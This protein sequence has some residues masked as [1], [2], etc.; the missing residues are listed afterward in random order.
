MAYIYTIS[1]PL[2]KAVVYVGA[3]ENFE[4]R[5]YAHLQ[6][7]R[8]K[9]KVG[10][11]IDGLYSQSISPLIEI[12]EEC[13]PDEML[14]METYWISQM[15]AWGFSLLNVHKKPGPN[16]VF[17]KPT[18]VKK[19]LDKYNFKNIKNGITVKVENRKR[20]HS[21][22]LLY[23]K[24]MNLNLFTHYVIIG[25]ELHCTFKRFKKPIK[26][27]PIKKAKEPKIKHEPKLVRFNFKDKIVGS[28]LT[29]PIEKHDSF[30]NSLREYTRR[31]NVN[32]VF[33]YIKKN[34]LVTATR[35]A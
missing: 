3:T 15:E 16:Q 33:T 6:S 21:S 1:H 34:N 2:T 32:M 25:G 20:F 29:V 19:I 10:V 30:K 4:T 14:I 8:K 11:F 28:F 13:T 23:K 22:F 17:I 31:N 5:K 27:K 9:N 24:K 18:F 7:Y 26:V 12:I 35:I